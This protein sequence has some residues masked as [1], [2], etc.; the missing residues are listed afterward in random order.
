M[1]LYQA[2]MAYTIWTN[3]ESPI[4]IMKLSLNEENK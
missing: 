4:E 2:A 1:L 3:K